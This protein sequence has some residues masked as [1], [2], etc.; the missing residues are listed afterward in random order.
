[1]TPLLT[2]ADYTEQATVTDW[3]ARLGLV[4]I[5]L[6]LI[7]LA[8][9]AMRR[10]WA[11]RQQRQSDLPAPSDTPPP[12]FTGGQA[13]PGLFAGTGVH[14]DWMDR[15][16]VHDLGVRSRAEVSWD[17]SGVWISRRGARSLF[18]PSEAIT[19]VRADRGVAG[20]VRAKDS[21]I[22]LTWHLG[23][24]V[25]DSG[26]RADGSPDHRTVLDGLMA[27]FS[28]GVR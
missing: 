27:T 3:P 16:A 26:F 2:A 11:H 8:L 17:D 25:L 13:I 19:D 7:G 9:W 1:M 24:R 12:G 18:I 20:T 10:G 6:V 21:M 15:I 28:T 14:G 4:L 23:D 22:L 5:V